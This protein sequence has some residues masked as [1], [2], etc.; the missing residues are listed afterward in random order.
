MKRILSEITGV[1][2]AILALLPVYF[3]QSFLPESEL[4]TQQA[5]IPM[6]IMAATTLAG[7]LIGNKANRDQ[8]KKMDEIAKE[9]KKRGQEFEKKAIENIKSFKPSDHLYN[10]FAKLKL[11]DP[12]IKN[13][14]EQGVDKNVSNVLSTS[15]YGTGTSNRLS[16]VDMA[17]K[18][19]QGGTNQVSQW[20]SQMRERNKNLMLQG[21]DSTQKAIYQGEASKN[22]QLTSMYGNIAQ[23]EGQMYG[24]AFNASNQLAM[25]RAQMWSDMASNLGQTV[26]T[27]AGG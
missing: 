14:L 13:L 10:T 1:G 19:R 24:A 15:K 9:A 7:T 5:W 20:L 25:N 23:G 27:F 17:S 2:V 22:Q 3:L 6:A 8:Q 11:H 12:V 4:G 26:S 21:E 16:L 18:I